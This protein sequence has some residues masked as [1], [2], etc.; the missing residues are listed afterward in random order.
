VSCRQLNEQTGPGI[1]TEN[2]MLQLEN[3]KRILVYGDSNSWGWVPQNTVFPSYRYAAGVPWPDVMSDALGDAY[4]VINSSM[5]GRT[6]ATD[7]TMLGGLG[8]AANGLTHLPVAIGSNMPLD[9]V[10]IMLGTNDFKE[11]Y[12]LAV[13]DIAQHTLRLAEEVCSNSG[14]ASTYSP[15][16]AL[17]IAPPPLGAVL[18]EDWVRAVFSENS[19]EKSKALAATLR[20]LAA[21]SGY[22]FFDAGRATDTDGV[23]GIHLTEA[24]HTAIGRVVAKVVQGLLEQN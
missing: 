7:D 18:D 11:P 1:V 22:E 12:G 17:I 15:A 14:V 4:E 2:H 6:C 5:P 24:N 20:P 16:P 21:A 10:V 8:R 13:S 19:I 9:Q 3:R 23:D